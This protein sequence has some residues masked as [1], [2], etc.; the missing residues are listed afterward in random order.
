VIRKV[1][2]TG[3]ITTIAGNGTQGFSGDG[4]P[5]LSASLYRPNGVFVDSSNN[6]YIADTFNSCVRK[7][8]SAGIITTIAGNGTP[9]YSGDGGKATSALMRTPFAIDMDAAGNLYIA[10]TFNDAIRKVTPAGIMTTVAGNG[11]PG[12]SGDGGKATSALLNNPYSVTVDKAGNIYIADLGNSVI[13]MINPAGII[14][15]V[16]GNGTPGYSGDGSPATWAQL[17]GPQSVAL[18]AAGN[19]YIADY[20]NNRIRKVGA[21][22][23]PPTFSVCDVNRDGA[24]NVLDVVV[25]V[26]MV[27]GVIPCTNTSGV[28]TT[29]SVQ[30]V[31]NAALGFGCVSP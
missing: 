1:S 19:F 27:L 4:G 2:T 8:N 21:A 14:S 10:D 30:R 20:T 17:L 13:R 7:I 24:I 12:Y 18:D 26:N 15:T 29:T 22:S 31:V 3:I 25:E 28:C 5:A 6:I 11:T 23:G 16:A 9:G